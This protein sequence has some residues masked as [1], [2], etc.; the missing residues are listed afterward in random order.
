M[1]KA[2]ARAAAEPEGARAAVAAWSATRLAQVQAAG[3]TL[4]DIEASVGPWTFAKLTIANAALRELALEGET[5][6]KK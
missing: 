1:A 3:R 6:R 2:E 4:A 5:R